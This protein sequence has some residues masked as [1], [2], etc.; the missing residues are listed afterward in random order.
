MEGGREGG[1]GSTRGKERDSGEN[2]V[3]NSYSVIIY[4]RKN[5][6]CSMWIN[7]KQYTPCPHCKLLCSNLGKL[8]MQPKQETS[9]WSE[10]AISNPVASKYYVPSE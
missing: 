1:R 6:L 3:G 4:P 8:S 10:M 7:I 2:R 9:A 5:V